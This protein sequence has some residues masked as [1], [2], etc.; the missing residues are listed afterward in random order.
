LATSRG[1]G[2]LEGIGASHVTEMTMEE[3]DNIRSIILRGIQLSGQMSYSRR[4]ANEKAI[5]LLQQ[6]LSRLKA[7]VENGQADYEVFSLLA[8]THENLLDY[9]EAIQA[10][11]ECINRS[12]GPKKDDLKRLARYKEQLSWWEAVSLTPGELNELGAFL[13]DKLFSVPGYEHSFRWTIAWLREK[14]HPAPDKVISGLERLGAFDDF[15]V[16]HNVI[17]G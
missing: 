2:L 10:V 15:Q 5:P 1:K 11:Q 12:A 13:H 8:L 6:A 4:A 17:V 14:K 3:I 9:R 7:I 16:L